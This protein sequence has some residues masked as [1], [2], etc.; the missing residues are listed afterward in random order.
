MT[1]LTYIE[2]SIICAIEENL[3]LTILQRLYILLTGKICK[4]DK[5]KMIAEDIYVSIDNMSTA[6]GDDVRFR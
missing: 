4:P 3:K 2:E 6:F 5:I 1:R